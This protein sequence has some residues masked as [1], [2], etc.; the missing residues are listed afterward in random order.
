[1]RHAQ[2]THNFEKTKW[3]SEHK[4]SQN[5]NTPEYQKLKFSPE[6]I[7]SNIIVREQLHTAKHE[8]DLS[9]V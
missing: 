4:Q 6:L 3:K 1:M 2:S 5:K 8:I 7:D 9:R